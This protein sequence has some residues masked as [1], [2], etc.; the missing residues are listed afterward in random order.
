ML[1]IIKRKFRTL[2]NLIYNKPIGQ[3]YMLHRVCLFEEGKI[4]LNENMKVSPE[5][6][7]QFIV[8]NLGKYDFLSLDQ[9]SNSITKKQ[10]PRRPFIAFTLDDGYF[11]NY[12]FAFPIFCKYNIPFTIYVTT[13]FVDRISLLWW[14]Q[15]EDVVMQNDLVTLSNG[16]HFNCETIQNKETSF[17]QIRKIIL[18]LPSRDFDKSVRELFSNYSLELEKYSKELI[19]TWDQILQ[20]SKDPLCTIAAHTVTHRRMSELS[21]EDLLVEISKSKNIIENKIKKEVIHF[22][23]PFGT[24]FEV[25]EKAVDMVKKSGFQTAT[26]ANGGVIRKQDRDLFRLTRIMLIEKK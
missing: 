26:F 15:L 9:I 10:N 22:A 5:F 24:G 7:E 6:L 18:E 19:L 20:M 11:D 14:Y 4:S 23:Y 1:K 21:D 17:L 25:N 2:Y 3:I 16:M 12:Q 13:G 8:E